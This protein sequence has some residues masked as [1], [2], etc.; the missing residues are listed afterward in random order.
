MDRGAWWAAQPMA[1]Q[2]VGHDRATWHTHKNKWDLIKLRSFCTTVEPINR[3]KRKPTE[4]E[5]IF[6]VRVTDGIKIHKQ[7]MLKI[8]K[9]NSSIKWADLRAISVNKTSKWP[10][11]TRK[12]AQPHSL[13]EKCRSGL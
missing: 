3:T 5:K 13:L 9:T 11:G 1:L 12:G 6:V 8:N 7:L 2:R 10:R 4:W